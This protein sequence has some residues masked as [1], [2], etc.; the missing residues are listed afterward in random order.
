VPKANVI[1]KSMKPTPILLQGDY[2]GT[3][4]EIDRLDALTDP[5]TVSL[6][7]D[8]TFLKQKR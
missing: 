1:T 2:E 8:L 3:Y 4:L 5:E 6:P 7:R